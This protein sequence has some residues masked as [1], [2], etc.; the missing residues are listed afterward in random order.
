M[1]KHAIF[2]NG[3]IGSGKSTLGIALSRQLAGGFVDG[4]SHSDTRKPWYC[5]ILQTSRSILRA[6][7]EALESG[8]T[9]VIAYPL[10]CANWIYFRRRFTD[11]GAR[12]IFVTLRAALESIVDESRG[13]KFSL[14]EQRRIREMIA[15]GYDARSFSDLIVDT[16]R[17]SFDETLARLVQDLRC[18]M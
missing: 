3:P 6:G 17:K 16:D 12:P 8:D 10:S 5:S 13:R 15:Q 7:L 9:V 14:E 2:L 4:D 11:G 1:T 18:M